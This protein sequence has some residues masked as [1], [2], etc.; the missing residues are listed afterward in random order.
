MK[1]LLLFQ[2]VMIIVMSS[3]AQ[4]RFI[5][6]WEG[7]ISA[8]VDVRMIIHVSKTADGQYGV[9]LDSPDQGIKGIPASSVRLTADSIYV[10][11]SGGSVRY[12]GKIV[13]DSLINGQFSQG[14]SF[15]VNMKKVMAVTEL[16]RPQTPKPPFPYRS[17]NVLYTTPDRTINYGATITIPEGKGP[18]PAVLMLTG[19]GPQ[20][21]D[22][23]IL[24]HR[25]FAVIADHLTRNGFVVLRVDDRGIGQTT[26][27]N[28]KATTKDFAEDARISF[29]YLLNRSEV[30]KTKAGLIGHSEGGMIAQILGADRKDIAF[31]VMMAGPG[32]KIIDLMVEQVEA[33]RLQSG[34]PRQYLDAYLDLY[35]GIAS[36]IAL[37]DIAAAPANAK[38]V[39]DAWLHKTDAVTALYA[40]GISDS[41]SKEK[42]IQ[43][44]IDELNRPWFRYF[45]QYD[46]AVNLRKLTARVL[47]LNGDKDIQ[48]ISGTNLPAIRS[49]LK[50]RKETEYRIMEVPGVNHLFQE[51]RSCTIQEYGT[52]EQTISP[53]VLAIITEWLKALK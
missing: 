17:E 29:E 52:L 39:L 50:D 46:P 40:T 44:F 33:V 34:M 30:D 47:A 18:F 8:G 3:A 2:L 49:A 5:G 16:N 21:R 10:E 24:G 51:C 37:S 6:I 20:N 42:F 13:N 25:P 19:S 27:D 41:A 31:I 22:E 35:R 12:A 43:N 45:L 53:A 7:K 48:V 1:K 32:T 14:R 9:S 11:V 4:D 15:P 36:S 38:N 26:G 28:T 23:E